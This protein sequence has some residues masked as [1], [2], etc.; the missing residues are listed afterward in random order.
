M[1]ETRTV[2]PSCDFLKV[3]AVIVLY[4]MN[5]AA[6][7]AYRSLMVARDLLCSDKA[8]V[9]ILLY[10]NS[11]NASAP[12]GLPLGV[13]YEASGWNAGLGRAYNRALAL[14]DN[15]KC[16]WLL[17]L[18]QDT[19]LPLD[20]LSRIREIAGS[21][22]ADDSIAAIV[23]RLVDA[24][25]T[26]SPSIVELF[27]ERCLSSSLSGVPRGKELRA[28][29]SASLFRVRAL[30]QIGGFNPYFW[31]DFVDAAVYRNLHLHGK[32]VYVAGTVQVE[33]ELSVI[34]RSTIKPERFRNILQAEGA[35]CDLYEGNLRGLALT[36]RLLGRMGRQWKRR[37][38][39]A[40][41][42]LT[43]QAFKKRLFTSRESRIRE[44]KIEME[45]RMQHS[46]EVGIEKQPPEDNL[47]VSVCMATY[48]GQ[49]FICEQL[50]SILQ[51]LHDGDEVVIVDDASSDQTVNILESFHDARIRIIKQPQNSGI[52]KTFSRALEEATHP[53]IFLADQD[54]IWRTDKISK[55]RRLFAER[56][57]LTLITS[58]CSTIDAAG[59]TIADGRPNASK[60]RPGALRNLVRN[61]YQGCTMAFRR[62]VLGFC[63]PFPSDLPMHDVWIGIV[64]DLFGRTG[65]IDEPLVF[66]R[67]HD[68]NE[69][70]ERHASL[71][72]IFVWRWALVKNLLLRYSRVAIFRRQATM[73]SVDD[74]F[75][76]V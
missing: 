51:Q 63:L 21:L 38:N 32:R 17:T 46:V 66:Y 2:D 19:T 73:I 11:S 18:D 25:R 42:Q 68:G 7:P 29:N 60:F 44:W 4:N 24:G 55:I 43:W 52:F 67:R 9:Q 5:H 26:L 65:Y 53:I 50:S 12:S 15:E 33:H 56:P 30:K 14:A 58:G 22:D 62:S 70:L 61:G 59:V 71:G 36:V 1:P 10:D 40:I 72:Q 41:R 39:P 35:F 20:F 75:K 64:N 27:G 49:R 13:R 16:T 74:S 28:L 8:D 37:D 57:D 3:L 69:S 34:R 45:R 31:L 76:A 6:S 48:N 47:A 54:D 23:P